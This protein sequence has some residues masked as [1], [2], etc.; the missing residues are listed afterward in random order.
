MAK[1]TKPV[2][3]EEES[4]AR[5]RLP[6]ALCKKKG[7][8]IESWWTPRDA[9]DALAGRGIHADE[10]YKKL[11]QKEKNEKSAKRAKERREEKRLKKEQSVDPDHS[12]DYKYTHEDGKIAGV[13]KGAAMS[14]EKA[15]GGAPN[16]NYGKTDLYGY[17][18]NCQTCVPVFFARLQGYDV[19]ALPNNRNGY[20]QELMHDVTLAYIDKK[21]RKPPELTS[22]PR[23]VNRVSWLKTTI[24]EGETC[25]MSFG[26]KGYSRK[27]HVI[28][29]RNEGG[30]IIGYDPQ[31]G[32]QIKNMGSYL[33]R[34]DGSVN[35]IRFSQV[36]LNPEYAD[37]IMKGTKK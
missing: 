2:D 27:G 22:S 25:S 24:P 15:D 7:I 36:E 6:F 28:T 23:G 4:P 12:P 33:Q 30:Q 3:D 1:Y 10:E 21:T 18:T 16:P 26:W 9:W 8:P 11:R 14:F 31:I 13:K 35:L 34:V 37:Y 19:R 5:Y 20:I 17:D 32:E 29:V